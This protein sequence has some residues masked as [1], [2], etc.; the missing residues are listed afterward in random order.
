MLGASGG[1]VG[2]EGAPLQ[3]LKIGLRAIAGVG[4][5]LLGLA[6]YV[7]FDRID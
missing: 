5:D 6:A 2:V 7:G 4:R 3:R 1:E